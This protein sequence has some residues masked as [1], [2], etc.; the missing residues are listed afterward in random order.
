MISLSFAMGVTNGSRNDN[1]GASIGI[2]DVTGGLG[3]FI[4]ATQNSIYLIV[5]YLQSNADW[6]ETNYRFSPPVE[7][8]MEIFHKV[9]VSKTV[10]KLLI[11]RDVK[12]NGID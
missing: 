12:V 6:P 11:D 1:E 4:E 7:N 9:L 3:N 10:G 2:K 8:D 5:A